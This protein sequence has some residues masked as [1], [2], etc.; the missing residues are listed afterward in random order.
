MQNMLNTVEPRGFTPVLPKCLTFV[1][2]NS[3]GNKAKCKEINGNQSMIQQVYDTHQVSGISTT[4]VKN[5]DDA[6]SKFIINI[7]K[8]HT[9]G[10]YPFVI[11]EVSPYD[12]Y[13]NSVT[14]HLK[15][16]G[17]VDIE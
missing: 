14:D 1:H 9:K 4:F 7:E 3:I 17:Y 2:E 13:K 6:S 16:N 10:K 15:K 5:K 12:E 8:L 11:L